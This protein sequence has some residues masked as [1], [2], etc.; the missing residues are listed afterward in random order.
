M[1]LKND[2]TIYTM[3]NFYGRKV[4]LVCSKNVEWIECEHILKTKP[5]SQLEKETAEHRNDVESVPKDLASTLQK[6][7]DQ[8][9]ARLTNMAK[10]H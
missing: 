10:L 7:I 3:K 5:M 2:Q 6:K 9:E 1:K 4:W 8:N